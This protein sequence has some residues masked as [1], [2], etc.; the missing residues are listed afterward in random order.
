MTINKEDKMKLT[1]YSIGMGDR[2][3]HQAK[4]QL[5][6]V[7]KAQKHGVEIA[8]VWNKSHREH[9]IIGSAPAM[10]KEAV[11]SAIKNSDWDNPYFLDADHIGLENVSLFI[12]CC[13]YFTLDVADAIGGEID[14]KKVLD[15]VEHC[16]QY[17]GHQEIPGLDKKLLLTEEMLINI[18]KKYL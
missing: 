8:P 18:T 13:N 3:G 6:V 15:Y 16:R 4:A 5:A 11:E 9:T 10:T 14:D 17:L 2:F 12:D 1:K 7:R